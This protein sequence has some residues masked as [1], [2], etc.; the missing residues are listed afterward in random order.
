MFQTFC[1]KTAAVI[2][3]TLGFIKLNYVTVCIEIVCLLYLGFLI[4]MIPGNK[5]KAVLITAKTA[6]KL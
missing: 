4:K 1:R 3:F 2:K 6:Q 5:Q